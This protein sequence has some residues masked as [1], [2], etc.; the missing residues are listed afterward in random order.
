[1]KR[2][3][4]IMISLALMA[5]C[6]GLQTERKVVPGNVFT[7][8]HPK[9]TVK[10]DDS[11]TYL[12]NFRYSPF[13]H[14]PQRLEYFVF[15]KADGQQAERILILLFQTITDPSYIWVHKPSSEKEKYIDSGHV[16]LG[17]KSWQYYV[18][19]FRP[20][21]WETSFFE[22]H[23]LQVSNLYLM[24]ACVRS[25][26]FGS[27]SIVHIVYAEDASRFS[28]RI[29][30]DAIIS[31]TYTSDEAAFV[32][33]FAERAEKSVVF[34]PYESKPQTIAPVIPEQPKARLK[35]DPPPPPV[36]E[37]PEAI[38]STAPESKSGPPPQTKTQTIAP[39]T[40]EQPKTR[41][42]PESHPSSAETSQKK[43]ASVERKSSLSKPSPTK[44]WKV[45]IFPFLFEGYADELQNLI[46]SRTIK[47]THSHHSLI[48]YSYYDVQGLKRIDM[49][50]AAGVD[51]QLFET[52]WQKASFFSP[53]TPDI[54]LVYELGNKL[55]TDYILTGKVM[56]GPTIG[57]D[58]RRHG[59]VEIYL[60]DVRHK[61]KMNQTILSFTANIHTSELILNY[62]RSLADYLKET[63]AG[64]FIKPR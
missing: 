23:G 16:I 25:S 24:K 18:R 36:Q 58:Y 55:K 19:G 30:K 37:R 46:I 45:A 27:R 54:D 60:I 64:R 11:L 49:I 7:S 12:G 8:N 56:M 9:L 44:K 1:M 22:K 20:I 6:A 29:L 40:P 63:I 43:I 32:H 48:V 21:Q 61:K 28:Y 39:V 53:F 35:P 38:A 5:G 26:F 13:S 42:R 2:L 3:A 51:K 34:M 15:A 4:F 14:G 47:V 62:E 59:S 17:G 50:T 57:S 31:N 41:S 10:V 33:G 52:L